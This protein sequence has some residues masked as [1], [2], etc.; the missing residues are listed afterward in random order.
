MAVSAGNDSKTNIKADVYVEVH[1]EP[2]FNAVA[3]AANEEIKEKPKDTADK[4][5]DAGDNADAE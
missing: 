1:E 2:K 3:N 4:D 5:A